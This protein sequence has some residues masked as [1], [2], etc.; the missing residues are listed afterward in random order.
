[1]ADDTLP[2]RCGI[3]F[4]E[5][6]GIC[7]ALAQ[8]QQS[9]ILRKGGIAEGPKG[10]SP[11]HDLFWLYPTRV[12]E[13]EQ[14]LKDGASAPLDTSPHD[15]VE[16]RALAKVEAV[17][18]ADRL[19]VLEAL[20]DLHAWTAETVAKR[21]HYRRPGLWVLGVRAFRTPGPVAI[22]AAPEHAGCKTWVPLDPPPSTA[23]AEPT[24]DDEGFAV[25]MDRL[26]SSLGRRP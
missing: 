12:H 22:A 19:D 9:L 18:F 25:R 16:L 3:A 13:A 5:W 6:A 8:G 26:R 24:L 14:G 10:F 1:M 2:P 4:K 23:G 20:D 21:F 11:E 17:W 15:V 7:E